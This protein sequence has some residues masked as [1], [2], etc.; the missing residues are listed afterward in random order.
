MVKDTAKVSPN[1]G[2]QET[3]TFVLQRQGT[4]KD[5]HSQ[6]IGDMFHKKP[7]ERT[8][9]D[10]QYFE[11]QFGFT[12]A[13]VA[14]ILDYAKKNG[15]HLDGKRS[16]SAAGVYTFT[17]DKDDF[18]KAFPTHG[19]TYTIPNELQKSVR[20]I[21]GSANTLK[22]KHHM[23]KS[24]HGLNIHDKP[25]VATVYANS[26][27]S[28]Y[29]IPQPPT[30]TGK[31][32]VIGLLEFGGGFTQADVASYFKAANISPAPT[33]TAVSVD[34]TQNTPGKDPDSDGEVNLDI[35]VVGAI[36]P[37]AKIVVYF[38]DNSEQGFVE[39]FN[40]AIT[41]KTNAPDVLSISW[42]GAE[43][44][45]STS[46]M[47]AINA[48]AQSAST[49]GISI[50][51]ASGDDGSGDGERGNNVDFPGSSPWLC[52]VGGSSLTTNPE[53]AWT[54]YSGGGVSS[55]FT[56]PAWQ[57]NLQGGASPPT[58]SGG[59]ECPDVCFNADPNSGYTIVAD[60]ETIKGVAGTSAAAPGWG[61]VTAI[62]NEINK[63]NVGFLVPLLYAS[64]TAFKDISTGNNGTYKATTGYDNVT[65][66]GAPTSAIIQV[67]AG[68]YVPPPVVPITVTPVSAHTSSGTPV[69]IVL[70][71]TVTKVG[72]AVSRFNIVSQPTSGSLAV[73]TTV[74]AANTISIT[75]TP[76]TGF[77]G[78]DSFT[79]N[80]VDSAG[81]T[82]N[83]ATVT[84]AVTKTASGPNVRIRVQETNDLTSVNP[85]DWNTVYTQPP[86]V[87]GNVPP[88]PP[89]P[90]SPPKSRLQGP[91]KRTTP[92]QEVPTKNVI[93]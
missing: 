25:N 83:T 5:E 58:P 74:T 54:P 72:A 4:K 60:G 92:K 90:P 84:I 52:C 63:K 18:E 48:A 6:A 37:G 88:P 62:A 23:A 26:I 39:A 80:A 33:V 1:V 85:T 75:Y 64:P 2:K 38:A 69:N 22:L 17:A 43:N 76:G 12:Q 45:W 47:M 21:H 81:D 73:G 7:G 30:A 29:G 14:P 13:D 34:G 78:T 46:G 70:A 41:D 42:G 32:Q 57:F 49:L 40:Y 10:P 93:K 36:A 3:F 71:A 82:S 8:Y 16:N 44:S 66:L 91:E 67:L 31:G 20:S 77:I 50:F 9:F 55:A 53:S 56:K 35:D 51:A 86:V 68:T 15:L 24:L 19:S 65:G 28:Y 59:R 61:G 79:Y 11:K 87:T 89:S 27:A